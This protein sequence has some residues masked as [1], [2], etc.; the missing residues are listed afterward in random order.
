MNIKLFNEHHINH[1]LQK[2]FKSAINEV[3]GLHEYNLT[4]GNVEQL[5][6]DVYNQ[7]KEKPL[8]VDF[9]KKSANVE[10][11]QISGKF[12]PPGADVNRNQSYSCA[13][14]VW[15]FNIKQSSKFLYSSPSNHSFEKVLV[16]VDN[17]TKLHIYYHTTY[18]SKE[19][20]EPLKKEVKNWISELVPKIENTITLINKEIAEFNEAMLPKIQERIEE[21]IAEIE[22]KNNQND[23]LAD[24]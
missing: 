16:D 14:V 11:T 22:K 19:L 6:N 13:R 2:T 4:N 15:S 23:D 24:F 20:S 17:L 3:D 9:E 18:G 7:Y 12:F 21:R 1:W 8:E 5:R 10:M